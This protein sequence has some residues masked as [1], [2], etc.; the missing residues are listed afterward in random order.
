[1]ITTFR[2]TLASISLALV[3]TAFA[4]DKLPEEKEL[5]LVNFKSVK[6]VLQKDGLSESVKLKEKKVQALKKEQVS[7]EKSRYQ[8]PTQDE[9]WGFISEYW[10]VKNAQ[11]LQWDFHKPDYGLEKSFSTVLEKLGFY[12]KKFKILLLNNPS[13]VRAGLP[14]SEGEV[15]L[16]LS[17]PFIRSLDL[18]KLEISLLLLEDFFRLEQGYF[19]KAVE[20]EKMKTLPGTNFYG[21]KPDLSLVQ[22]VLSK[23]DKQ[24]NETGF[25]FQQQFEVT[26]KMDSFLKSNPE[27]WNVYFQ[28]LGKMDRMVK[29]NH[30]YKDYVRLYPSPEM[31]V[32]W[33]SPPEKVL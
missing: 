6:K 26:K 21:T 31:Q 2:V 22:E 13:I 20:T 18:S 25:T 16:L 29:T 8:Y 3:A 23:Y 12:Q 15:I 4:A 14:G 11:L 9:L 33:L 28:L 5:E 7:V 10:L 1:M 24:I 30:Q 27:L 32:K 17:V 19:K